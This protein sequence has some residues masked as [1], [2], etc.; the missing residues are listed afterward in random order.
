MDDVLI[1][2]E[3]RRGGENPVL[4]SSAL[5]PIAK[6]QESNEGEQDESTDP[7]L[8]DANF[9]MGLEHKSGSGGRNK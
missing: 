5:G 7:S 4:K 6:Q 3:A 9:Q 2:N 8:Q 1:H